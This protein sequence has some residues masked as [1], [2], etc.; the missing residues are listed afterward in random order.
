MTLGPVN[1]DGLADALI[2]RLVD[3]IFSGGDAVTLCRQ[4]ELDL[5]REDAKAIIES[6]RRESETEVAP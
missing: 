2:W 3:A 4:F 6:E 5:Y 1:I